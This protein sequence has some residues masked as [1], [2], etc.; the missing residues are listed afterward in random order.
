MVGWAAARARAPHRQTLDAGEEAPPHAGVSP[1]RPAYRQPTRTGEYAAAVAVP[2]APRPSFP[3]R[4]QRVQLPRHGMLAERA[5][6]PELEARGCCATASPAPGR[7]DRVPSGAAVTATLPLVAG[8][9]R[10]TGPTAPP[11]PPPP[12]GFAISL[13][14][15]R[16]WYVW[17]TSS[18]EHRNHSQRS[19]ST[20]FYVNVCGTS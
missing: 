14:R 20:S 19:R 5:T 13:A 3:R 16:T 8:D 15:F 17:S 11:P 6:P 2:N 9:T 7:G 10:T 1:R 18:S 12:P 4:L